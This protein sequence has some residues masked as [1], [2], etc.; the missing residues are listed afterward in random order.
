MSRAL[1]ICLMILTAALCGVCVLQWQGESRAAA[2]Q[3]ALAAE[4]ADAQTTLQSRQEKL[5]AWEQEITRLN[6]ALT[7]QAAAQK[8][9][10]DLEAKLA[11]TT[12][13]LE[14]QAAAFTQT[15]TA[16][17][18]LNAQLKKA[19]DERDALAGRLN[20]RTREFNTLA[21]KY[22]KSR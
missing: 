5:T 21:E 6:A 19:L 3:Q 9:L 8:A 15:T 14:A 16:A 7:D 4:L 18:A 17:E 2:R 1:Q 11:E 22:R 12:G 13:Q 20:E 10:P